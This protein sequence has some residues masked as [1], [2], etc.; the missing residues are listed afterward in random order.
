MKKEE[1]GEER[2][3]E[4]EREYEAVGGNKVTPESE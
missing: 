4:R 2:K 3:R 1:R